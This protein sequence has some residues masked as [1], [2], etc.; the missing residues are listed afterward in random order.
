MYVSIVCKIEQCVTNKLFFG[1]SCLHLDGILW[2][3]KKHQ[4]SFK[5]KIRDLNEKLIEP[6]SMTFKQQTIWVKYVS[7]LFNV[8]HYAVL[9]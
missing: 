8:L 6:N 1:Y 2:E 7:S 5:K 4:Q 3:D 9:Y